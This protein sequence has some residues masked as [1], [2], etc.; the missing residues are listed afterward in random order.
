MN[1]GGCYSVDHLRVFGDS[2]MFSDMTGHVNPVILPGGRR[3]RMDAAPTH[4][5]ACLV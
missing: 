5:G 2:G 4:L 3:A 1:E